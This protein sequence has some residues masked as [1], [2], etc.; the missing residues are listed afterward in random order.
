MTKQEIFDTVV[1]HLKKQG[2]LAKQFTTDSEGRAV[3]QCCYRADNGDKCAVGCLITDDEYNPGM[4]DMSVTLLQMGD[5]L[6]TRL[7]P[8]VDFLET[9]QAA[10]DSSSTVEQCMVRLRIAADIAGL[11]PAV[12][13]EVTND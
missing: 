10:H 2:R 11:N 3:K 9:L 7:T 4:E 12:L 5:R 13:D 1:R 8:H 6:P